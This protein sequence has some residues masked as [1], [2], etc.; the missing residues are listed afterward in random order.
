[1]KWRGASRIL[2]NSC[3]FGRHAIFYGLECC[4]IKI[5]RETKLNVVEIRMLRWMYDK[6][7]K[8]RLRN[9]YIREAVR[10]VKGIK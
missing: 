8:D 6:T 3:K 7:R 4:T 1:M 2:C 5:V 9:E 10:V